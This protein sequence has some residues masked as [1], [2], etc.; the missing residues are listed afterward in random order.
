MAIDDFLSRSARCKLLNLILITWPDITY[1]HMKYLLS[2]TLDILE[3]TE[4]D[5]LSEKERES[6]QSTPKPF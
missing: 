1:R 4:K 3:Q 2:E 5:Y 6:D